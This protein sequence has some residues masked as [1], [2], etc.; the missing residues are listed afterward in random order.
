MFYR[1]SGTVCIFDQRRHCWFLKKD[2]EAANPLHPKSQ[3]ML[4]MSSKLQVES[5]VG[6]PCKEAKNGLSDIVVRLDVFVHRKLIRAFFSKASYSF[7]EASCLFSPS[8]CH[9]SFESHEVASI[10]S[11]EPDDR[12]CIRCPG[13][14]PELRGLR[15]RGDDEIRSDLIRLHILREFLQ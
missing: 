4:F 10:P 1:R 5:P 8:L 15:E 3:K 12:L 11:M 6:C 13:G 7:E 2:E 9:T 14:L